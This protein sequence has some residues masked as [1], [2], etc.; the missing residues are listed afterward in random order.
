MFTQ[1]RM[2]KYIWSSIWLL[3]SGNYWSL[4]CQTNYF[5]LILVSLCRFILTFNKLSLFRWVCCKILRHW[6]A[7]TFIAQIFLSV[8]KTSISSNHDTWSASQNSTM[9]LRYLSF[10]SILEKLQR[11]R[12]CITIIIRCWRFQE[13]NWRPHWNFKRI[14]V[15]Y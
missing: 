11:S 3:F 2:Y 1:Y 5:F 6:C 15:L 4:F 12:W 7:A 10:S 14:K 13:P 9:F 8:T